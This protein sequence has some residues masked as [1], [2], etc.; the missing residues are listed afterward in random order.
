MASEGRLNRARNAFP[1]LPWFPSSKSQGVY[2]PG[3]K[4]IYKSDFAFGQTEN[5]NK[6]K[7]KRS[8]CETGAH[9]GDLER[10][11]YKNLAFQAFCR[12]KERFSLNLRPFL[13]QMWWN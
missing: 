10:N 5:E 2:D 1:P 13:N 11:I 4:S 3:M 7:Q 6:I 9:L 8:I 12:D